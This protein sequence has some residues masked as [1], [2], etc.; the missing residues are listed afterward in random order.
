M[1]DRNDLN[2]YITENYKPETDSVNIEFKRIIAMLIGKDIHILCKKLE[3]L[4][5]GRLTDI[6]VQSV[7]FT[8]L[9]SSSDNTDEMIGKLRKMI[10]VVIDI[11]TDFNKNY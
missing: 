1:M 10:E 9:E 7:M 11:D 4:P 8:I 2:K 3:G 5:K 6:I